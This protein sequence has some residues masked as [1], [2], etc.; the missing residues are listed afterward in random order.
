MKTTNFKI[1]ALLMTLLVF[2]F[3]CSQA[4]DGK[5]LSSDEVSQE[6]IKI[7]KTFITD[8]YD[9]L[10]NGSSYDFK[11]NNSTD[12][13]VKSFSPEVQKNAYEKI[14]SQL[15]DYENVEYEEAWV[16]SSNPDLKVLRY[17]GDFTGHNSKVEVRVVLDDD[18]KIAG[19]Y[20]IPW[21]DMMM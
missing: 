5:K 11:K 18:D 14:K 12:L 20:V 7:G 8:F 17:K 4:Q 16:V 6:E 15:G 10:D 19:F 21:S 3:S 2:S 1:P 9:A 13:M